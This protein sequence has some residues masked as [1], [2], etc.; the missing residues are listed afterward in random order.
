MCHALLKHVICIISFN[1]HKYY[2]GC[3]LLALLLFVIL[4]RENVCE[5]SRCVAGIEATLRKWAQP[6]PSET[7]THPLSSSWVSEK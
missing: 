7:A 2:L 4:Q 1:T 6:L 5:I 3:L